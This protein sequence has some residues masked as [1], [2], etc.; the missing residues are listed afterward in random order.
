MSLEQ[1]SELEMHGY[2][3]AAL[4][5]AYAALLARWRQAPDRET[6]LRLVRLAWYATT[7]P[8]FLTGPD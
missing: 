2:G 4:Q 3:N 6:G 8:A 5:P 7:E 1:I